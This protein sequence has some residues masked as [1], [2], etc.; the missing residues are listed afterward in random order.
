MAVDILAR[1]AADQARAR[2]VSARMGPA[3]TS[4]S[5]LRRFRA[6]LDEALLKPAHIVCVGDSIS[7]GVGVDDPSTI[8]SYP[9]SDVYGW[10]GQLRTLFG[11]QYGVVDAGCL[12]PNT[13]GFAD[14]RVALAGASAVSTTGLMQSGSS[15]TATSNSGSP[16]TMTFN[17]P[18]CTG[19]DILYYKD[20]AALG[21]GTGGWTYK[22]DG[23][24]PVVGENDGLSAAPGGYKMIPVTGLAQG[25]HSVVVTATSANPAYI[26]GVRYHS[27]VGACVTRFAK[28]GGILLDV[29]GLGHAFP[30]NNTAVGNNAAAARLAGGFGAWAP[31]L[32]IIAFAYND[33]LGQN[34]T[35]TSGLNAGPAVYQQYLQTAVNRIAAA[36]G[37]ALL[38]GEPYAPSATTPA[39]GADYASYL[40]AMKTVA[41]TTDHVAALFVTDFWRSAAD[42]VALGL[43]AS[44]SSIHPSRRGH[45]SIGRMIHSAIGQPGIFGV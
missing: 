25:A 7:E 34:D 24:A 14:G 20:A 19:F 35:L 32:T 9:N 18:S 31:H 41:Q 8:I 42:A 10:P 3:L 12:V 4:P 6:A 28:A 37:C 39:G 5:G 27:G 1:D 2:L 36:G 15:V 26:F 43:H 30:G 21:A 13:H 45:G 16:G 40:A 44:S 29:F 11:R 23:G 33:W 17:L 22:I 38:L